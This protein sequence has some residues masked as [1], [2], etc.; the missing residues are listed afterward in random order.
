M[1][2]SF[3]DA[4]LEVNPG[5]NKDR[6]LPEAKGFNSPLLNLDIMDVCKFVYGLSHGPP[7]TETTKKLFKNRG[8][9]L[10]GSQAERGRNRKGSETHEDF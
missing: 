1:I 7:A 2:Q 4:L 6:G 8:I 10:H 3:I 5:S 9:S